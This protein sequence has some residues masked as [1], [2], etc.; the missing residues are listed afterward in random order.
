MTDWLAIEWLADDPEVRDAYRELVLRRLRRQ[1]QIHDERRDVIR[2]TNWIS[3][4]IFAI[5]HVI[6]FL[7]LRAAMS[8]F[9]HAQRMRREAPSETELRVSLEGVAL[10]TSLHGIVLLGAAFGFY[11]LYLRFVY[12]ITEL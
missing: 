10:K 2:W 6:L 9:A 8:E 11:F 4:A 1:T 5:V 7:G 12:P 3:R